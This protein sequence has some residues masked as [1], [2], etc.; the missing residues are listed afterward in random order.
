M[1]LGQ[2]P[3]PEYPTSLNNSGARGLLGLQWVQERAIWTI[4]S[5]ICHFSSLSLSLGDGPI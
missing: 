5:I 3:V 4:F 2:L 1:V